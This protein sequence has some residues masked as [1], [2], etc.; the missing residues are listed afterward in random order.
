[1][2][3]FLRRGQLNFTHAWFA[4]CLTVVGH[5]N[6]VINRVSHQV[7]QRIGQCLYQVFIQIG[8]F[9]FQFKGDFFLQAARQIPYHP[10]E[11]T[12]Y[13]FDWLHAGLHYRSLQ[14]A[15]HDIQVSNGLG[16]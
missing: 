16:H 13:F 8:F 7:N 1:M 11:A 9:P 10:G 14:V 3:P 15:G 4:S 12:K 2:V 5:F 6:T